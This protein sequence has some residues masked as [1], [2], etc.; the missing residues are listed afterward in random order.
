MITYAA[1]QFM[2]RI[3]EGVR[4][5][6]P[7]PVRRSLRSRKAVD[8]IWKWFLANLQTSEMQTFGRPR[9]AS[10]IKSGTVEPALHHLTYTQLVSELIA[11]GDRKEVVFPIFARWEGEGQLHDNRKALGRLLY[12]HPNPHIANRRLAQLEMAERIEFVDSF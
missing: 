11:E 8:S 1:K 2:L 9:I 3:I 7:E 5:R 4:R 10:Q 6:V 12:E